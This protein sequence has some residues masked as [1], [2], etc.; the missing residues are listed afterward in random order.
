[1]FD[2]KTAL[3]AG[4]VLVAALSLNWVSPFWS[5][6]LSVFYA[7][8]SA[9]SGQGIYGAVYSGN[10]V[11]SCGGVEAIQLHAYLEG[12]LPVR[13]RV[14]VTSSG[15]MVVDVPLN[16]TVGLCGYFGTYRT[17]LQAGTYSID[18]SCAG[19]PSRVWGC[20]SVVP[21]HVTVEH[22]SLTKLDIHMYTGV[23]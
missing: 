18:L 12:H 6:Y 8:T 11:P 14:V 23:V 3:V 20:A 16:W 15:G 22:G 17:G 19:Y 4:F 5:S 9:W 2:V 10:L 1:M 7:A 13:E 21:I